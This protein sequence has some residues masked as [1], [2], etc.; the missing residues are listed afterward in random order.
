[1]ILIGVIGFEVVQLI[2]AKPCT[3]PIPYNLG[4]FDTRFGISR[5]SFLAES[6]KAAKI[7]NTA[8]GKE[9]FVYD[10]VGAKKGLF[11]NTPTLSVN[12]V[13]DDRQKT[14]QVN[15]VLDGDINSGR[16]EAEKIKASYEEL[17]REYD[18]RSAT[19]ESNVEKYKSGDIPGGAKASQRAYDDLEQERLALNALAEQINASIRQYNAIAKSINEDIRD[20]NAN[21][22]EEFEEG[23]Y[24]PA[25]NSIYIYQF[26]DN[27]ELFRVLT[28][29]FG[30]ALGL[31]HNGNPESIMYDTNKGTSQTLS[32]EDLAQLRAFC[33]AE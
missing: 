7:W 3:E 18:S 28:H 6:A 23:I 15:Q 33:T 17:Q 21:V 20:F 1:M 27:R 26:R 19:Y 24:S 13:Y 2:P 25:D 32:A 10:A 4:G 14:T 8:I 11:D 12:L 30:H 9:I 31:G 22:G 16:T 5:E 29:E